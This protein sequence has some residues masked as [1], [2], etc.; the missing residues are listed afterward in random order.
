MEFQEL[1]QEMLHRFLETIEI[2]A[3]EVR[4]FFIDSRTHLLLI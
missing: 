2:K 1:T 4:E 3:D